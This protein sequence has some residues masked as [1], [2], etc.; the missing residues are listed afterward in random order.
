VSSSYVGSEL[1]LFREA[2]RWKG[3][4][5]Q[6]LAQ[7]IRGDVLE[8]GAGLGG[9][10]PAVHSSDCRSWTCL[11]PDPAMEADLT[12]AVADLRDNQGLSP[13]V[14]VGSL[15][16]VPTERRFDTALYL[17]VLEHIDDD[18][19]EL[20][21]AARVLRPGGRLVVLSPA[22]NW[23]YS[24][25][26]RAIGHFRR[27]SK[28]SLLACAPEGST[29]VVSRYLDSAGVA[30]SAANRLL[31]RQ[32]MPSAAQIRVWDRW[33]VPLSQRL[34]PLTAYKLGKSVLAV[35]RIGDG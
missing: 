16:S 23:L 26:D 25:F 2:R 17:D 7:H 21:R 18:R 35:W 11:E 27:Y 22:W 34:D 15:A 32:S 13:R 19:G 6:Q 5:R 14:L 8:V 20:A 10:T 9:T 24:P 12:R 28:K 33:L 30:A 29:L 3:Y 1:E 31:M 4:I